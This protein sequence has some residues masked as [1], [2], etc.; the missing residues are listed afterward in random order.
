MTITIIGIITIVVICEQNHIAQHMFYSDEGDFN[1]GQRVKDWGQEWSHI[2][3]IIVVVIIAII[4]TTIV[5]ISMPTTV[6]SSTVEGLGLA[7]LIFNGKPSILNCP[8]PRST[9]RKFLQTGREYGPNRDIVTIIRTGILV[10]DVREYLGI[11]LANSR[12]PAHGS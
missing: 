6:I 1:E 11:I 8:R 12:L 2:T 5:M 10:V 4:V 9:G 3:I 7:M